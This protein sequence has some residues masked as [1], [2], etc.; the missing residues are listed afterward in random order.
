MQVLS[1]AVRAPGRD[2]A[3]AAARGLS[4]SSVIWA[5]SL[6]ALVFTAV[7]C[8]TS[9]LLMLDTFASLADYTA[10]IPSTY[11]RRD[12]DPHVE[13]SHWQAGVFAQDDWRARKNLTVSAGLREELQTHLGDR[14]NFSPRAGL[15]WSP[16]RNGP[17]NGRPYVEVRM[18]YLFDPLVPLTEG[19]WGDVRLQ[20]ENNFAVTNY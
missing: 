19:W 15:T 9:R 6:A 3:A 16:F 4:R 10:G 12:G 20:R 18:C 7:A 14:W 2:R 8:T 13:Y 5:V 1:E 17:A 11:T